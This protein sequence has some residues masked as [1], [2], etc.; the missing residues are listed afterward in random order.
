MEPQKT[1]HARSADVLIE[2]DIAVLSFLT[3]IDDRPDIAISMR[4]HVLELLKSR[5]SRALAAQPRQTPP[6]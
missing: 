1:L 6:D 5:I 3:A 4:V 2:G